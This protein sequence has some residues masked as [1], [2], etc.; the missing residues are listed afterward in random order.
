MSQCNLKWDEDTKSCW[1]WIDCLRC[2]VIEYQQQRSQGHLRLSVHLVPL[3]AINWSILSRSAVRML[4]PC[5]DKSVALLLLLLLLLPLERIK[6]SSSSSSSASSSSSSRASAA[7]VVVAA[8][9]DGE[10]CRSWADGGIK[11]RSR[12]MAHEK[13][14]LSWTSI[15]I[16]CWM[17]FSAS[18]TTRFTSTWTEAIACDKLDPNLCNWILIIAV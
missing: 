11:S 3:P 5:S 8:A 2:F 9:D 1:C 13:T 14:P 12:D 10:R 6:V 16:W 18:R 17:L 4:L 15:E 7:V